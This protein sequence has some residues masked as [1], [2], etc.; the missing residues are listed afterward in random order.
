MIEGSLSKPG[1][2]VHARGREWVVLPDSTDELLMVRPLGGLD[3]EITGILPAVEP[4]ESAAFQLPTREDLGDFAS[5]RLLRDA[6]RLSTRAAAGPFRSFG[7]IAAEP[8]SYQL[9]PLMMA[10]KLDPIRLLIADDVGIG[11]TVEAAL[12]ARELFD[13]GEIRHL[14][15]L[16]PPHLAEQW[17]SELAEKFHIDAELVL[18]S[19]IQR[20]ERDLPLGTS[21]FDRHHFTVVST[22]FIK[23]PRRAEDFIHK[24][25][26]F[27]I[28]DEAHGCTLAS[29][30][31][32]G[33]QQRFELLRRI[34]E[35]ESR[36][37][38]LVT[39]TPHSGNEDAFRS[40]LSL[41][42]PDFTYL[43]TDLDRAEREGVRRRL[44][45]HLV[46]RRRADIRHYLETDTA[47]PE[48]KDKEST[49][50]FSKD[51][52]KLF[53]DILAFAREF[54]L[55]S[56]GGERRRRVRY[57]SALALLRCVSSSPDAAAATLRSRAVV[58]QVEE[59]EVEE[60]GR[61][62]VLDQ[63]AADDVVPLDLNPGSDTENASDN[64]RRK[65]LEFARRAEALPPH[66]DLK[67]Q[68]AVRELKAL[69][70]DGF[71]PVVFCRFVDSADYVARHLRE[72]MPAKVRIE[73]VTG[74]L[75]PAEREA[76]IAALV[77]EAGDYVLVCTDCLS[78]GINLQQH[79]NAVLHY[80]LTWNP[81]RHEQR[82]GRVDRFGQKK[83]EVRV[84]TYYGTDN[85]IDG[86]ILDV[87]L[88]K[89]KSIK[90]ALGV[91]VAVPGSSEQIAETLFEG[92]LFRERTA[93]S[94]RQLTLDFID[95]LE[96]RKKAIHTEW[97]NA[98]DREKASRSRFAHHTLSPEAVA[99][100]LQSVRAAIGR[101]EDV[102]GFFYAVL[103]AA[104]VPV[105][106]K[107]NSVNVHLSNEVPR[108]LRQAIGRDSSF[109]GRF[110]LPLEEGE[111]YLGRTSP[112]IEGLAGWTLDQA[113]DP[114]ARDARAVAAR[115]GVISTSAVSLRTTLL[116][117]RL[118]YH[119]QISGADA[120]TI[121]CEEIMPLACTGSAEAPQW[122]SLE[123]GEGLLSASPER[124]LV[125]TAIDQQL[126]L[127]LPSLP[128]FQL[129]LEPVA[130][131]R[132]TAQLTAH[133]RVREAARTKGRV[134]I[135]PVL[136]VDI[137]GAYVILPKL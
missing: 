108:A 99:A 5:G 42:D 98:R 10:L 83:K 29:G 132:A 8:R 9:V 59:K 116:V 12:I 35:N 48:R 118:R 87:L 30:L 121:L 47:F 40:L 67:L 13:R 71:Q 28:V 93:S 50:G 114:V 131:E 86:V 26:E 70:K 16:C 100:E 4:V 57:W 84:V 119:L 51:Y 22:D 96:P 136:P 125:P 56:D 18:S 89:H 36:H 94:S 33:R 82:E 23:N 17:Q 113:L 41:L 64:T 74:L 66:E 90:S 101:S 124:N 20:L 111:I 134:T 110:D 44:A 24:C 133:E 39:A 38:V 7:R 43:P 107:G 81:T 1:T 85:P 34:A 104:N 31:G 128:K 102:A 78:E 109:S 53:D 55:E 77:G 27:V 63:D 69:I 21:V 52:R 103:Q 76:R 75:P 122:L 49:Y 60:V 3:E 92:A 19:T 127:V 15:V 129:A 91:T 112:I 130:R 95:D 58:D 65:L 80:D 62:T 115:C 88:R 32:R 73:S 11:K 37:L 46:Q 68:G 6:A 120:E 126:G 79:F 25:P 61:R 123:E 72:A 137:L 135:Q 105:Q 2:L 117:V 106:T 45:R 54:V 14:T 97:D